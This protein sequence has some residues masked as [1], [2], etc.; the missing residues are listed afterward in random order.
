MKELNAL[1]LNQIICAKAPLEILGQKVDS[2]AGDSAHWNNVSASLGIPDLWNI[3]IGAGV[4]LAIIVILVQLIKLLVVN[5]PK[6]VTQTKQ[7]VVQAFFVVAV[8][9][10]LAFVFDIVLKVTQNALGMTFG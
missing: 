8:L 1:L 2:A 5:Y 10:S 7:K 6:T 9:A 3:L 4:L